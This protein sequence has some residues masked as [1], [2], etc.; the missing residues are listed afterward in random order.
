MR[1]GIFR[2]LGYY[3]RV[4]RKSLV[5]PAGG[6]IEIGQDR[7]ALGFVFVHFSQDFVGL[8]GFVEPPV[9]EIEA[10]EDETCFAVVPVGLDSFLKL[11]LGVVGTVNLNEKLSILIVRQGRGSV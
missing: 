3:L 9:D 2:R 11:G 4:D 5:E 6:G 7:T 10:G 1:L 8:F